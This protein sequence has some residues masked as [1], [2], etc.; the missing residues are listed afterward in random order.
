MFF[1]VREVLL[2]YRF[3]IFV[4][5]M[6]KMLFYFI[7]SNGWYPMGDDIKTSIK[8]LL[9]CTYNYFTV[10]LILKSFI[11]LGFNN[12]FFLSTWRW[13]V[14]LMV[15]AWELFLRWAT[16]IG[17]QLST[18]YVTKFTLPPPPA[19]PCHAQCYNWE[20]PSLG[21]IVRALGSH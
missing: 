19:L 1:S 11:I 13:C 8:L 15:V 21:H 16:T 14:G 4:L 17:P 3:C 18:G 20:Y 7:L 5:L 9:C 6:L 12:V 2:I 10:Y